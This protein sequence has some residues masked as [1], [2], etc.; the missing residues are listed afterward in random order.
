MDLSLWMSK[1]ESKYLYGEEWMRKGESKY[2]Y[3]EE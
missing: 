3:E 2:P 1:F